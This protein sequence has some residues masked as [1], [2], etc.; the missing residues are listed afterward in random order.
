M[1]FCSNGKRS[2]RSGLTLNAESKWN[3][4][5]EFIRQKLAKFKALEVKTRMPWI[6]KVNTYHSEYI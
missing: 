3:K 2:N 6:R 1:V 4:Y 5:S